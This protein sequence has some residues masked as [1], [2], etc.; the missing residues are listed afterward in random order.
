MKTI[1]AILICLCI[2]ILSGSISGQNP[3]TKT[4]LMVI[5]SV[6]KQTASNPVPNTV[7]VIKAGDPQTPV[8]GIVTSMFAT[9]DVL[10]KAVALKCNLIICHEP[11]FYNHRDETKQFENDPVFLEKK[12]FIDENKLVIWRFHDYIHRIKPDAID[13]GMTLKLGW[14]K[15]VTDDNYSRFVVPETTLDEL[16]KTLKKV[17][18]KSA[19]NVVGAPGMK[20]KNVAFSAGAPGS[21]AHFSLLEDKNVDVVIAG[22]VSQWETYEYVR[23]AVSQGRNKAIIFLGHITSEEPGMEYCAQWLKG[24][25]KE[26]PINFVESGSSYRTY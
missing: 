1:K 14:Q 15:Y 2:L 4:A 9:M 7:D 20:L 13:Y 17:F 25:I 12:K 21:I 6:I 23:D 3:A 19:F 24:F 8:T 22:E 5:E 26:I 16:I 10:K 11:V 18:P